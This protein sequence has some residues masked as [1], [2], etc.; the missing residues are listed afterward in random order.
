M[1]FSQVKIPIRKDEYANNVW[2]YRIPLFNGYNIHYI[3]AHFWFFIVFML[4]ISI[5]NVFTLCNCLSFVCKCC[6]SYWHN[7]PFQY[8]TKLLQIITLQMLYSEIWEFWEKKR[9]RWVHKYLPS[10]VVFTKYRLNCLFC[11]CLFRNIQK[12]GYLEKYF[13]AHFR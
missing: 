6:H 9:V 13:Q 5:S 7:Q 4:Y 2:T 8:R 3:K 12:Y 10:T 11:C 1:S